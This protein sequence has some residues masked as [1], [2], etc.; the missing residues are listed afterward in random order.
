MQTGKTDDPKDK[1]HHDL[2][3][4]NLLISELKPRK[5][6]KKTVKLESLV[7][8]M[9]KSSPAKSP[10]EHQ[11]SS[12]VSLD[13][14]HAESA[15]PS[16]FDRSNSE[17]RSRIES[18]ISAFSHDRSVGA[19]GDKHIKVKHNIFG[20]SDDEL[21]TNEISKSKALFSGLDATGGFDEFFEDQID[22][23]KEEPKIDHQHHTYSD[24]ISHGDES[25]LAH[26]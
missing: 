6:D 1:P 22:N 8:P 26:G 12:T 24:S 16:I 15:I 14:V 19:S 13:N 21:G 17:S 10:A 3:V 20:I 18:H 2:S 9:I 5:A 4:L 25:V 11:H 23:L 7:T